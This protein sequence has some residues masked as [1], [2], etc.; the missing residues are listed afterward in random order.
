MAA[1]LTLLRTR[2]GLTAARWLACCILFP[3]FLGI[4]F[5]YL[6]NFDQ[7]H[8]LR[9]ND[10]AGR[11]FATRAALLHGTDP[12]SPEMLR[13]IQAVTGHDRGQGFDYPVLLAVLLVPVAAMPWETLRLTFLL[14]IIPALFASFWMC[15][16]LGH[17]PI[18][19]GSAVVLVLIGLCSWPVIFALR[20]QQPTLIVAVLVLPAC[21]LISREHDVPAG[22]LLAAATFKPQLVLPLLLWLFFWSIVR[23]RWV[24]TAAFAVSEILF[25]FA[26]E[27]LV[28]GWFPHW[29]ADLHRYRSLA[30]NL[31]LQL[32]LGRW[33][34][35]IATCVLVAFSLRAFWKARRCLP[36]SAEFAQPIAV[37][38]AIGV[39]V[40][41]ITW[42]MIYNQILLFPGLLVLFSSP[43]PPGSGLPTLALRATQ[44]SAVWIFAS[45][46][47]AG[48]GELLAPSG[49]WLPLP[50]FDHLLAPALIV[51]LLTS[52]WFFAGKNSPAATPAHATI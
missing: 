13:Q 39:C 6:H 34:G 32:F 21:Y 18:T 17:V 28:P 9:H 15:I 7:L 1:Q 26:A 50:F 3:L 22:V 2:V 47:I 16:R 8:D 10:L 20:L 4:T 40:T 19:R 42:G 30:T 25:L 52:P 27:R 37:A 46:V 35:L 45:I 49:F 36:H 12:Y 29:L 38:L 31:P 11:Q 48:C 44:V 41:P 14:G 51:A 33:C 43:R 24:L 23:R 5:T